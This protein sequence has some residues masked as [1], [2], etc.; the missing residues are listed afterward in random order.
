M[1]LL[2]V[3]HIYANYYWNLKWKV[4][5][6]IFFRK[7]LWPSTWHGGV[8]NSRKMKNS[9]IG[10]NYCRIAVRRK[11]LQLVTGEYTLKGTRLKEGGRLTLEAWSWPSYISAESGL[12]V[13]DWRSSLAWSCGGQSLTPLL[14]LAGW[15]DSTW[16]IV[17]HLLCFKGRSVGGWR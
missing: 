11:G 16:V 6:F 1:N 15:R 3:L 14:K 13:D 2:I 9:L 4:N 8:C 12:L 7:F 17:S 10:R 5:V